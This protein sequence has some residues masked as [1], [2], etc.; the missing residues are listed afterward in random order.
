M[1]IKSLHVFLRKTFPEI[2]ENKCLAD[3]AYKT[4]A[5]DISLFLYKYKAICGDAWLDAF[6]S[7]V[8]SLRENEVHCVFIYD[9]PSPPEKLAEQNRRREERKKISDKA[10]QLEKDI[11]NYEKTGVA[12]E[13][14]ETTMKK[15]PGY[16]KVERLLTGKINNVIDIQFLRERI[17]KMRG[18]DISITKED[19]ERT[20]ILFDLLDIPYYTAVGE[21]ETTCAL[22]C[23][24]KVVE[25][26]LSED[27]DLL[28]Y[29]CPQF[30]HNINTRDHT[31][32]VIDMEKLL[33]L[34]DWTQDTF[35]DFCIMCGTDYNSN[36]PKIGPVKSYQLLQKFSSIDDIPRDDKDILKHVRSRELF[37]QT[38]D[39]LPSNFR[40]VGT[41]NWTNLQE[42]IYKLNCRTPI[43][44]IK[45][46]F[47]PREIILE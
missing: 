37:H 18:Q 33:D 6:L 11:R 35:T 13:L 26:A 40:Y 44:K 23:R 27:T 25:G 3:F 16:G 41:P 5:V 30:V 4:F 21:A 31:I 10:S 17:I 24:N 32:T 47:S 28:A 2:Y 34:M 20:K 46:A 1:G 43:A 36:I 22:L 8:C 15:R 42:Y 39:D 19:I 7:L 38:L 45:K 12:S 29:G 14:M 9:G